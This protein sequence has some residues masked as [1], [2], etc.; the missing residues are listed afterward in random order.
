[1][2]AALEGCSDRRKACPHPF[3]DRKAQDREP[4]RPRFAATVGKPQKVEGLRLAQSTPSPLD[5]GIPTEL[6]QPG[7]LRVQF[8][9]E[10]FEP[11]AQRFEEPPRFAFV[12]KTQHTVVRVADHNHI[13]GGL[14]SA[15]V[16]RPEI[17]YV[18]QVEICQL[19]FNPS[20]ERVRSSPTLFHGQKS[21]R[22]FFNRI[23]RLLPAISGS[24]GSTTAAH[25]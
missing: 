3:L 25:G 16:V 21:Q 23:G 17:K 2:S 11:T 9:P 20:Y 13:P 4:P 19:R 22:D 7:L 10:L 6:D 14:M 18:M 12:L 8:Q 24:F 5:G 15:P 1:M